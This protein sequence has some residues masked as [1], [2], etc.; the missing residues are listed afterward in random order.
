MTPAARAAAAIELLADI[1]TG[2]DP[3]D[4]IIS[5]Y[6]RRRRYAGS[7]DRRAVRGHVYEVLRNLALLKWRLA[8]AGGDGE[9]ARAWLI[10]EIAARA[11]GDLAALFSGGPFGPA[12]LSDDEQAVGER[13]AGQGEAPPPRWAQLNCPEWLLER[14]DR[15]FPQ[16]SDAEVHALNS[17]APVDLRVNLLRSSREKVQAFLH[18]EGHTVAPT[19]L[20]PMGLRAQ[21]WFPLA[22]TKAFK[23]GLVEVQDESSQMLALAVNAQP[24]ERV[25]DLCAGAGGK[26]LALATMMENTGEIIAVDIS[27]SRLRRMAPRLQRAGV[28]IAHAT[29][30]DVAALADAVDPV[31][32]VLIDAPCSSTGAWRRH[33][34][35]RWH[36]S[37]EQLANY[38]AI[39]AKLLRDGARLL[40]PGGWLVYATCSLLAEENE[41]QAAAFLND[42]P[43]FRRVPAGQY[44]SGDQ[45]T[46]AGL[47]ADGDL[48]LSPARNGTDGVFAV[49]FERGE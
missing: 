14:F 32:R 7:G 9:D 25:A 29:T 12:S 28:T 21:G 33:P 6:F 48:Y 11:P 20:S 5:E 40:G 4:T 31:D 47:S 45:L 19:P 30:I 22:N 49:V 46:V 8:E 27:P 38:V 16:T 34:E 41:E 39:Q 2:A 44:M 43:Q 1:A 10:A 15:A 42:H 23:D 24:G 37:P 3:A 35:S 18:E 26:T 13:L 36:L 17:S